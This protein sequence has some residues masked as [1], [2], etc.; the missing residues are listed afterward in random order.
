MIVY[1]HGNQTIL[2]RDVV[3]RQQT[4]RQLAQSNLNAVLVAP[5]LAVDAQDSAPAI[6]G[7]PAPS[8]NSSTKPTRSSPNSIGTS[9]GA[10]RRM[11]VI[12][13]AYSGGY[14]PA[15]YSLA[16]GGAGE[17]VRGVVLLDALYGEVD[18]FE[19]WIDA[20]HGGAFFLSAYSS[21]THDEN[22]A[23]RAQAAG[24]RGRGRERL[25]RWR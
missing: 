16:E 15:A 2:S 19:R 9:R 18:K 8:R 10:F 11:P 1:F 24:R 3:D 20:A 17:R 5:Q 12:I 25:A 22:L 13:V 4:V 7:G 21:S 6:S 23:L 14:M